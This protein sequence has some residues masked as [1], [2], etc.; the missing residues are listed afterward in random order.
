MIPIFLIEKFG[1]RIAKLIW[2][3][4]LI[5]LVLGLLALAECRMNLG[6]K[7]EVK[8]SKNQAGAAI[9]S[10]KAAVEVVSQR[11]AVDLTNSET[12][13]EAQRE[14]DRATT[15]AGVSRAGLNGL[16]NL[17]SNRGKPECVQHSG[18]R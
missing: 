3:A 18:S 17:P 5:L 1:P 7:T 8:L 6:A 14:I 10:G 2:W 12:I 11:Q 16:C 15:A 13:K 9:E 4:G